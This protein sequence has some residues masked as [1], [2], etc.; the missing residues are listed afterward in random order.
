[1]SLFEEAQISVTRSLKELRN[2]AIRAD[3]HDLTVNK[4]LDRDFVLKEKLRLKYYLEVD[5]LWMIIF[6]QGYYKQDSEK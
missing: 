5:T 6:Q 2:E 1:M 3:Y 4:H